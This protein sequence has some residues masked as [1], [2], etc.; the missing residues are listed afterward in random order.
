MWKT[1][2]ELLL[3]VIT[4]FIGISLWSLIKSPSNLRHTISDETIL[5]ELINIHGSDKFIDEAK[6]I[7]PTYGDNKEF[8]E[9][10][11]NSRINS[12]SIT[13]NLLLV[14][15]VIVLVISGFMGIAYL[16]IN[17]SISLLPYFQKINYNAINNNRIHIHTVM[18]NIYKWN[19]EDKHGCE[20]YCN[21]VHPEYL[22][23]YKI[24]ENMK[25]A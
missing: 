15:Y 23:L 8:L 4:F 11:E 3:A 20:N 1:V 22:H 7:Q 2:I 12:L 9:V 16:I 13:R 21:V 25:D 10:W 19:A 14:P 5:K 6:N 18:L 17:F 24:I